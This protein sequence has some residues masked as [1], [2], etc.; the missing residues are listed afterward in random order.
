M[1]HV[2]IIAESSIMT[3]LHDMIDEDPQ[4][5]F[6]H[7]IDFC[8]LT[9]VS[10]DTRFT[11]WLWTVSIALRGFWRKRAMYKAIWASRYKQQI[12][13]ELLKAIVAP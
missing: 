3:T 7:H 2:G 13:E 6:P 9:T 12:D 5:K 10:R 11:Y 1:I 4:A 8:Y